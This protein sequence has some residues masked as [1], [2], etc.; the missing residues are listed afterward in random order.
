LKTKKLRE[1]SNCLKISQKYSKIHPKGNVRFIFQ[2]LI[3]RREL[4]VS[5]RVKA[6]GFS[7][8]IL[9][10]LMGNKLPGYSPNK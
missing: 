8:R 1:A 10:T 2:P 5:G 4:L 3:F 9:L 7:N 6:D